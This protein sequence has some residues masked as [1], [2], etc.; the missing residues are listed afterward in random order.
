MSEEILEGKMESVMGAVL[1]E[2]SRPW[3]NTL[4]TRQ[5]LA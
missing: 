3:V 1:G 5:Q 4:D 2:A